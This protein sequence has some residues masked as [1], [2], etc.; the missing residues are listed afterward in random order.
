MRR[1]L[2]GSCSLSDEELEDAIGEEIDEE[3]EELENDD[4]DDIE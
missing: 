2:Q 1:G 4:S 3:D